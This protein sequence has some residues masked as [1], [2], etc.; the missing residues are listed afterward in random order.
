[1]S[2]T[3]NIETITDRRAQWIESVKTL[4]Q[5]GQELSKELGQIQDQLSQLNGAIQACD[6]FLSGVQPADATVTS[7]SEE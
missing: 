5:K 6:I 7:T 4:Q 2:E 3:L 1:M